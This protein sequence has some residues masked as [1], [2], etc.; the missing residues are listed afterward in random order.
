MAAAREAGNCPPDRQQSNLH[1]ISVDS[2]IESFSLC[3]IS[4]GA[5]DMGASDERVEDDRV[6]AF[7]AKVAAQ[8]VRVFALLG[9]KN[10]QAQNQ[11]LLDLM[12]Q[13]EVQATLN[14][15]RTQQLSAND[16]AED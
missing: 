12:R 8:A 3:S 16:K 10:R 4:L 11:K 9:S 14:R 5:K 13:N 6:A 1:Q 7:K 15:Y 2:S